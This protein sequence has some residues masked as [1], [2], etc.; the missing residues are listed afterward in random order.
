VRTRLGTSGE[1]QRIVAWRRELL[2]AGS[3]P[4][5]LAARL[6]ADP[7]FDVHALLEL[8]E[9]GCPVQ[10]AV[11]I[12]APLDVETCAERAAAAPAL[13]GPAAPTR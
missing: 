7:R 1:P 5:R 10:L 2:T 9:R 3:F 11:R 4:P 8:V 6:A 13:S 12:A